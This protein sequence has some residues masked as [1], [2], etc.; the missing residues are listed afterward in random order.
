MKK[1]VVVKT[2]TAPAIA[3]N[4]GILDA[5]DPK[6][7]ILPRIDI[8]QGLSPL[9]QNA[10]S[11]IK[12]GDLYNC[13]TKEI[14]EQPLSIIPVKNEK[15]FIKWLPRDQGGGI[16]YR[17]DDP[18]DKDVIRDTKWGAAGEKPSCTAYLNFLCIIPGEEMPVVASF[19]DTSY[20]AGRKLLTMMA[21]AGGKVMSYKLSAITKTNN[22][23]TF[24]VSAVEKGA[25]VEGADLDRAIELHKTFSETK[26]NFNENPVEDTEEF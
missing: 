25:L 5:V 12:V 18:T 6:D 24:F 2:K 19:H 20:Q 8:G 14:Y 9:V 1:D 7:L 17:K 3:G 13:I 22:Y 4:Q 23:G 26:M 10:D 21:M 16:V 11:P 15:N